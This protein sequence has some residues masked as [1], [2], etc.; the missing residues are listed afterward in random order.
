M[1]RKSLMMQLFWMLLLVVTTPR[2]AEQFD[3][4]RVRMLA[5]ERFGS[6]ISKVKAADVDGWFEL[7][8]D[9]QIFYTD[10]EVRHFFIGHIIES[11]T[12]EDLT[13][14]R[15]AELSAVNFKQLPIELAVKTV[16]GGGKRTLY[17][18]ED[19][20]CPYC[21]KL[22]KNLRQLDDVT[23]Y[24]FVLAKLSPDSAAKADAIW[25]APDRSKAWEDWM[26]IGNKPPAATRGCHAPVAEVDALALKLRIR[27][28][29]TIFFTDGESM[30]GVPSN[31]ELEKKLSAM[32]SD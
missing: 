9:G 19:P 12:G 8:S 22:H 13:A 1:T 21:K 14:A 28:T 3:T 27:G 24:T 2:A 31:A 11:K 29:P 10:S 18:F 30:S 4:E 7:E 25:C 6:A 26:S 16:R 23:V 15:L 32:V 20:Y 17:I 5:S